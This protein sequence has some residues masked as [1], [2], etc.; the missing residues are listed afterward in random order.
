[1]NKGVSKKNRA[2][3]RKP[4]L[5]RSE[6]HRRLKLIAFNCDAKLQDLIDA[7]VETALNDKTLIKGILKELNVKK[8]HRF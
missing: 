7:I 3:V 2:T 1:V 8:S 5:I 4:I 6:L